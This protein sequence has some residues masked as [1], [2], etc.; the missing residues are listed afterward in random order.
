MM[1]VDKLDR[2]VKVL[3]VEDEIAQRRLVRLQLE[4]QGYEVIE[5][6]NG[7]EGMRQYREYP[8]IRLVVTDLQ[9]PEM[10]GFQL[11]ET[12]RRQQVHYTYI[13]VLTALDDRESIVR[14]LALGADDYLAKPVFHEE[15]NLRLLGA[16]RLLKLEGQSELIFAMAT[17]AAY[18]SGETGS[19]LR[20]V[21]EYARIL[22]LHLFGNN[23]ELCLNRNE[24]EE[25]ANTAPLHD[26]G[27]VGIP[28]SVLHKPGK[29]NREE[30]EL[31][32]THTVIGGRLLNEIYEQTKSPYLRL[33]YEITMFH[34]E[35]WDGTGYPYGLCG[36]EIPVSA[37][38]M[39]LAD[40]FDA[41]ITRRSYKPSFSYDKSRK[42]IVAASGSHFDPILVE[43]C[44][45]KEKEF[46]LVVEKYHDDEQ[47]HEEQHYEVKD[48]F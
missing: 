16:M 42:I 47:H 3:L 17:L 46:L 36:G 24:V 32:K 15:L 14:A 23:K 25:I 12:I 20:R 40:V 6:V 43:A 26:I 7:R 41:L 5:A 4:R 8:G 11:I 13:V 35:R 33:A 29:L 45:R 48:L 9:M 19:H 31:M 18:R 22:A 27:K 28:D 2:K 37:R 38:I 44:L 30:F 1:I 21:R 10:D 34:H 39:A